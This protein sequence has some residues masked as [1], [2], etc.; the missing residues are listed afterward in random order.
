VCF[1]AKFAKVAKVFLNFL[2]PLVCFAVSWVIEHIL[3]QMFCYVKPG[4]TL[5]R[6]VSK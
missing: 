3:A 4:D 6:L 2:A 1:T 5:P